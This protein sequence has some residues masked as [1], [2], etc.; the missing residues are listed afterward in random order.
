MGSALHQRSQHFS[1]LPSILW[2]PPLISFSLSPFTL[3]DYACAHSKNDS[4][5]LR[6]AVPHF[7][8]CTFSPIPI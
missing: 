6:A 1:L 4:D 8:T 5:H 7:P 3:Y 2:F